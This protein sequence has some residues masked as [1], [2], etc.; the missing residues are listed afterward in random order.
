MSVKV[1]PISRTASLF[2]IVI[3]VFTSLVG[4][5]AGNLGDKIAGVAFLVLGIVLYWLLYRLAGKAR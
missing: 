2:I 3:G 4:W 5:A 1:S